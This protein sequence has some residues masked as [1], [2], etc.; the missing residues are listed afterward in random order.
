LY[1]VF[2]EEW[3]KIEFFPESDKLKKQFRYADD[4]KIKYCVLLGKWELEKNIYTIKNMETGE[5]EEVSL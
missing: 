3:K 2:S 1:N 4:K 5:S